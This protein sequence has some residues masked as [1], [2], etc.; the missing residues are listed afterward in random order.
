M[1][2]LIS[3]FTPEQI[4]AFL[5]GSI[6]TLLIKSAFD[7]FQKERDHKKQMQKLSYERKI[8]IAESGVAFYSH[9]RYNVVQ[10][11]TCYET[12]LNYIEKIE[13]EGDFP[14]FNMSLLINQTQHI[15]SVITSMF[16]PGHGGILSI[17]LYFDLSSSQY[18]KTENL[19]KMHTAVGTLKA[20]DSNIEFW[21]N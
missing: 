7:I 15:S 1:L 14:E 21:Y 2:I 9:Y 5:G 19:L 12:M 20:I 13:A 16:G 10:L 6:G 17:N 11:K 8:Q 3:L 18:F 4:A